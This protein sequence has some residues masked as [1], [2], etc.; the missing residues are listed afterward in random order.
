MVGFDAGPTQVRDLRSKTVD[1]LIA[2]HPAEIGSKDVQ[3]A[4]DYLKSGNEP[5]QKQ[6]KTGL[7]IVTRENIEQ[8]DIENYLYK[9]EC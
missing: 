4:V 8:S 5:S 1:T 6:V 7:T 9:A 3:M 2:Q